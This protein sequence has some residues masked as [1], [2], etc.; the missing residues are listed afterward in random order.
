MR[1]GRVL[2]HRRH[3]RRAKGATAGGRRAISITKDRPPTRDRAT[4]FIA[5]GR[6]IRPAVGTVLVPVGR[7]VREVPMAPGV[8]RTAIASRSKRATPRCTS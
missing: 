7:T 4:S 5:A 1:M 3:L 6:A 2:C 8:A